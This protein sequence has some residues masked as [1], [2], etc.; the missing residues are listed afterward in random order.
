MISPELSA[1]YMI[2]FD[3]S[4]ASCRTVVPA[5]KISYLMLSSIDLTIS[6]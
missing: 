5:P 3:F 2:F 4:T 6:A 1:M